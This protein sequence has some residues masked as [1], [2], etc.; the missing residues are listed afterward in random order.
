MDNKLHF[1]GRCDSQI[2]HMGYR[3]ELEEIQHALT[4]IDGV[5]EAVAL[6]RKT[7]GLSEIIA[8]VA[9]TQ[10]LTERGVRHQLEARLPFY[11]IPLRVHCVDQMPKNA[12]GKTDRQALIRQYAS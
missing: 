1:V 5:D 2:K 10:S 7:F 6:Q 4:T 8:V 11:M 3:I 12:N 9:T